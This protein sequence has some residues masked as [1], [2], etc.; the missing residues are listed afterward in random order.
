VNKLLAENKTLK[1]ENKELKMDIIIK[2]NEALGSFETRLAQMD[3]EGACL[4]PNAKATDAKLYSNLH[5][6][7]GEY[8]YLCTRRRLIPKELH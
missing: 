3:K 5:Y 6:E 4:K 1:A 2:V 7:V 8:G